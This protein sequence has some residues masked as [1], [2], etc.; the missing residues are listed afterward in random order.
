MTHRQARATLGSR[1]AR[2]S[3]TKI[4]NRAKRKA[5]P[6]V[7]VARAV[8]AAALKAAQEAV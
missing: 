2:K 6:R 5:R 8:K 3:G 1:S 4:R 7:A